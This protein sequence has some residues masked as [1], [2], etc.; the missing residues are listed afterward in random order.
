MKRERVGGTPPVA[1]GDIDE[2]VQDAV[3]ENTHKSVP[4]TGIQVGDK[5]RIMQVEDN[6]FIS[7]VLVKQHVSAYSEAIIRFTMLAVRGKYICYS[8]YYLA[9]TAN[10]L[11]LMMA[12]Q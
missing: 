10:T 2:D 5:L 1:C 9:V 12:A 7:C 3:H 8:H 6:Q 4:S 11:N